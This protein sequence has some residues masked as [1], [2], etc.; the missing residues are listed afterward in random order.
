MIASMVS[1]FSTLCP[2][3]ECITIYTLPRHP[4]ITEAVSEM[5]LAC[6]RDTLREFY[7]DSPLTKEAR[8]FVYRLLNLVDLL[9]IIQGPTSLPAVALPNL[10]T[11]YVEYDDDL[12]WLQGFRGATLEKLDS[13][14]FC[15]ESNHIGDFLGAFE[16]FA[17][18]TSSQNTLSKLRFHTSR[19][20]NPNYSSLLSFIQ[21]KEVEIQFSCGWSCSSRVDDDI[22]MNLARAMP[23]LEILQLGGTPCDSRTGITVNG[24]IG[25]AHR[26]PHLSKLRVHFQATSLVEAATGAAVLPPSDGEPVVLQEDCPLTNLEVGG[27]PIPMQSGLSVALVLLQIFPRILNIEYTNP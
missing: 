16:N 26:S 23:K 21:L 7:V 13:A 14:I 17:F 25:L 4:V 3:L 1:R 12:N 8:E 10:T 22:I 18:T 24:L 6:N 9:A 11:I 15:S 27:I 20:W 5:V 2:D 19:S